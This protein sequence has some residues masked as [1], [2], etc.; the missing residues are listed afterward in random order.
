MINRSETKEI[1]GIEETSKKRKTTTEVK[2]FENASLVTITKKLRITDSDELYSKKRKNTYS[3]TAITKKLRSNK[4]EEIKSIEK[5]VDSLLSLIKKRKFILD[6]A[7]NEIE[8]AVFGTKKI[9]LNVWPSEDKLS[10][11]QTSFQTAI[12]PETIIY[13]ALDEAIKKSELEQIRYFSRI[14]ANQH[15]MYPK[16]VEENI[17]DSI[18]L[19]SEEKLAKDSL[20]MKSTAVDEKLKDP[21]KIIQLASE[22]RRTGRSIEP[23]LILKSY[24]K[25]RSI[26]LSHRS[27][28]YYELALVLNDLIPK[29]PSMNLK[30]K[31]CL[32]AKE[33]CEI[34]IKLQ[35]L[36]KEVMSETRR[37]KI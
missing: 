7:E 21:I 20:E 6:Q 35:E 24:L 12:A 27:L 16:N 31:Y 22:E 34:A 29:E 36:D 28:A 26:S 1:E 37:F 15:R 25:N 8:R 19:S 10:D 17:T 5:P 11:D 2:E 18:A 13:K 4:T 9:N 32:K 23:I 30:F 33:F 3:E 14:I